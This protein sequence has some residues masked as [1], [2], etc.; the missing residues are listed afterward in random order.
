MAAGPHKVVLVIID[1]IGDVTIP[2]FG[3]RTP[4]EVAH[5]PNMDALAGVYPC[6]QHMLIV[7]KASSSLL[8]LYN[9]ISCKSCSG[10]CIVHV[11]GLN[12]AVLMKHTSLC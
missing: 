3:D 10:Q 2:A 4:L 8:Q 12:L 7:P 11:H 1:G 9:A 6:P 5:T